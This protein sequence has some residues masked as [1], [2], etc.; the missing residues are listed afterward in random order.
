MTVEI[1]TIETP[2]LGDRS[3]IAHDG[4]D[5]LVV[6]P[7]RDIDRILDAADRGGVTITHVFET[8][9]HNDYVSGGLALCRRIGAELV[10]AADSDLTF[11]WHGLRDGD[12]VPVGSMLV[13]AVHTPGHTHGH[14]AYVLNDGSDDVAVFTGGSLLY[15]TVGRTDL[16]GDE[17]TETL[18]RA[19]W[20]SARRLVIE[21][22]PEVK[23]YP[24]HGFGSFCSSQG[25]ADRDSGTIADEAAE[26]LA[27]CFDDVDAFVEQL[28]DGLSD[29]P[30]YYAHM[31]LLNRAGVGEPDLGKPSSV[32]PPTLRRRLEAG[33]WV[34]DLRDRRAFAAGHLLGS[35]GFEIDGPFVT[36]VGWLIPWG[37]RITLIADDPGTIETAQRELAR[38]GIDRP[39]GVAVGPLD[40]IGAGHPTG[41]YRVASFAE[42]AGEP[43]DISVVDVRRADEYHDAHISRATN[44]PIHQLL[45][46]LHHVPAGQLWVHC[47]SGSRAAIAASLLHRA[48]H[49][50]VLVD[51]DFDN[52]S[53]AGLSIE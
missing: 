7:Q 30:A 17:A 6:D 41:G 2:G 1:I 37:S 42:L 24:T 18:T 20:A 52:A 32:D 29:Y 47:A 43:G 19:Q 23:V 3:Y 22:R 16:V 35:A 12:E 25:G 21:L 27:L 33:E 50:V 48:G 26:N 39:S 45:E 49:D 44:I 40:R 38:I 8:H 31:A 28:L 51:D 11:D 46:H 15:G 36:Y 10:A 13:R 34:L 53:S 14:L 4:S 9:V 5:A